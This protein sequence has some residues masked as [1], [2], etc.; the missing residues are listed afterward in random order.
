MRLFF[1]ICTRSYTWSTQHFK[2][3]GNSTILS[4]P[5][6]CPISNICLYPDL[7]HALYSHLEVWKCW[8]VWPIVYNFSLVNYISSPDLSPK[9]WLHHFQLL[10]IYINNHMSSSQ[11]KFN[12]FINHTKPFLSKSSFFLILL[13]LRMAP[14]F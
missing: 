6:L 13:A 4:S 3:F 8:S 5:P 11:I 10:F 14:Q 7:Q 2:R 12:M 9:L 1:S